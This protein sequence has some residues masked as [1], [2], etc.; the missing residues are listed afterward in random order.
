MVFRQEK[1]AGLERGLFL[2]T[3]AISFNQVQ[4]VGAYSQE[5]A[6][7]CSHW[8]AAPRSMILGPVTWYQWRMAP[9]R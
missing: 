2:D 5:V 6:N 4:E 8:G 7:L 1:S 9:T 3:T